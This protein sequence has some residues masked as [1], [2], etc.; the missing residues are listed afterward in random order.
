MADKILYGSTDIP[1]KFLDLGDSHAQVIAGK[2]DGPSWSSSWGIAGAPFTSSN[3]SAGAAS[4][5]DQPVS[6]K[7]LVIDDLFVSTDTDLALTFLEET[8]GTVILGPCYLSANFAGQ[9]FTPRG[10][11]RLPTANKRLQVL[12]SAPGNITVLAGY[13]SED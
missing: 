9:I 13:P 12:A 8:S 3:Q 11:R 4:V 6:G 7:R 1:T 10:K 5:T 2:D